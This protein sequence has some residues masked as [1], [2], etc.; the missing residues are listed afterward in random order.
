MQNED[1]LLL[2]FTLCANLLV[3]KTLKSI[4]SYEYVKI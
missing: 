1:E 4:Y 2:A 3:D